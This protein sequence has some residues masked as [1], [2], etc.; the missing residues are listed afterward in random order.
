MSTFYN[1]KVV[2]IQQETEDAVSVY[3][4]VPAE[5]RSEFAYKP[6]QYISIEQTINGEDIRRAYSLCTSPFT[7]KT[8]AVT[9]KK[10]D[11]GKMSKWINTQLKTGD[12]IKLLAPEG[13][14]TPEINEQSKKQYFLFAGGSGITPNMSILKTVLEKEPQSI[15]TLIYANRNKKTIIFKEE[16]ET[17]QS[18]YANRLEVIHILDSVGLFSSAPKGPMKPDHVAKYISKHKK[19]AYTPEVFICG[20]GGM[21]D[22]VKTGLKNSQIPEENIHIEYFVAPG[23]NTAKTESANTS[24]AP[25][26]EAE[27]V[28]KL[29]GETHTFYV[30]ARKTILSGAQDAGLDPPYSCEAGICSSCMAKVTEG[31]VK[32]IENN[33]LTAREVEAGFVLTCQALCTSEKVKVEFFE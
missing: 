28:L 16:L 27:V 5:F 3:F 17:L 14:F 32:M 30:G 24:A 1:A 8:P 31:S 9:V 13:R 25:I 4:E 2:K 19:E 21:M 22:S 29:N 10:V 15:I 18:K 23:S 33:I 11:G 7:D 20:P 12:T 26:T 6:G